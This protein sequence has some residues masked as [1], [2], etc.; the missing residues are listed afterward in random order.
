M[1][2][3]PSDST[4]GPSQEPFLKEWSLQYYVYISDAKVE[5]LLAQIEKPSKLH[6]NVSGIDYFDFAKPSG[7]KS[8]HGNIARRIANLKEVVA[9][10]QIQKA[11]GSIQRNPEY[12]EGIATLS[13]GLMHSRGGGQAVFFVGY[14]QGELM[15]LVGS[16]YH[17]IGEQ[18]PTALFSLSLLYRILDLLRSLAESNSD[19]LTHSTIDQ[20]DDLPYLAN[21]IGTLI[22]SDEYPKQRLRFLAKRYGKFGSMTLGSPVF[23]AMID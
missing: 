5:M 6:A 7:N 15:L 4:E 8:D 21:F 23:V 22:D 12:I 19:N 2:V 14:V 16:S 1:I 18:P 20:I 13:W 10:L 9:R 11:V 3:S 17:L